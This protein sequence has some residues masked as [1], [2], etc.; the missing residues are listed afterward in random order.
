MKKSRK[1]HLLRLAER[2]MGREARRAASRV[3]GKLS[4]AAGGFGFVKSDDGTEVFVPAKMVNA[5]LDGDVVK[6]EL[7][8]PRRG[9]HEKGPCGRVIEVLEREEREYVGE[10]LERGIVRPLN[11]HLPPE[12]KVPG[13]GKAA[14]PGDWVR[15]TICGMRDGRWQGEVKSKLGKVGMISDDLDAVM[16]EFGIPGKYSEEDDMAASDTVP[17]EIERID[18]RNLVALTIDPTDA[19]DFD[20]AVSVTGD[21]E[22]VTVG[23]HIADVAAYVP[24]RSKIDGEAAKR[25]FSC[26]LPGRTLPMLPSSL[27]AKISMG[28][29]RDSLAHSVFLDVEKATGKVLASRREHSL[30]RVAKRLDYTEVRKVVEGAEPPPTWSPEVADAVARL[31]DITRAMRRWRRRTEE[32]IDLPVPEVRVMCE[33][34]ANVI[35]GFE[36]KVSTE[37]EQ[38]VEECM[39]AANSAVGDE[40]VNRGVAGRFRIHPDPEP[41]RTMEFCSAMEEEFGLHPGN[42]ANRSDCNRFIASISDDPRRDAVLGM[43]LRTMP[44]ASYDAECRMHF[45]LGKRRY[46]HFTSPIRRYTD[47]TVHQQ[48]W[49]LDR[50]VRTRDKHRMDAIAVLCTDMEERCDGASRAAGD[51]LKLRYFQQALEEGRRLVCDGVVIKELAAGLLVEIPEYGV[52]G[53]VPRSE[54]FSGFNGRGEQID[55]R[56]GDEARLLLAGVDM[57]RGQALFVPSRK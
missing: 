55:L 4:V 18:R 26:Y 27:T 21:G 34:G 37:S 17:R 48:L 41:D 29:G 20:D 2:A 8:P 50:G 28:E 31:L 32:F 19:K 52:T 22:L 56:P 45:A 14:V 7:L 51:R 47:L 25:G 3:I 43:L 13:T 9:V 38:L 35:S 39:L 12:I 1:K 40:L 33:E 42:V 53:F 6:L 44:R 16:S 36:N 11:R 54:T 10:L 5:A 24:P 30:I 23:V 49:N 57:E 46:S 15:F